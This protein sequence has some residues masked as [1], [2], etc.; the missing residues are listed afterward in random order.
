MLQVDNLI[1]FHLTES[2]LK[3][4]I[5][6]ADVLEANTVGEF[7]FVAIDKKIAFSSVIKCIT[8]LIST[9]YSQPVSE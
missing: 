1:V 9:V 2:I 3:K 8:S 7:L 6:L 5:P 4:V